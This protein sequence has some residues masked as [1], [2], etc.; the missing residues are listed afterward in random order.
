MNDLT[1]NHILRRCTAFVYTV[2]F[3]KRGLPNAHILIDLESDYKF[4]TPERIDEVVRFQKCE[5]IP[6]CLRLSRDA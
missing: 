5:K 3:Q 1:V 2:E 6:D 4:K